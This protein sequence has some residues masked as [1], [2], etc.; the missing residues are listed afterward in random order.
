MRVST[1]MK[2]LHL[3][4]IEDQD[5]C[6]RPVRDAATDYL[7]CFIVATRAYAAMIPVLATV[8]QRTG[9]R[10]VLDLFGCRRSVALAATGFG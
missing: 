10:H 3:I 7:Q 4:E 5:W 1:G 8:L 2:R 6:P 9:S